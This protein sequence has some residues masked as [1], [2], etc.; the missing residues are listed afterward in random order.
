MGEG[1]TRV[2]FVSPH[3]VLDFTNGA[4]TATLDGLK[5]LSDIGFE[6]EAFCGSRL[7]AWDKEHI[8]A[9][10]QRRG[11]QFALRDAQIGPFHARMIFAS[12]GKVPVTLVDTAPVDG[13]GSPSHAR[14]GLGGPSYNLHREEIA[15]FLTGCEVFLDRFRPDVVW[16]YGG[17]PVALVVQ[18]IA[19]QR[20]I[21]ILF[22]L[23]NFLYRDAAQ[24]AMADCA[25]VPTEFARR[26]YREKLGLEC[27]VL[28]LVIDPGRINCG[29]G[30]QP[31]ANTADWQSAPRFV[32]FVNP[33]PRKGVHVFAR[34]AEVLSNRRPD[35]PLL[36]VEGASK[37]S[38]LPKLG[39]D[40]SG[41][42]N[43]TIWP[44]TPDARRIYA[45]S[46]LILMPSLMENAGC[47][48]MEAM[49][50]GIPVLASNRG[51][52][53]ET[54]GKRPHPHPGP[55][56]EGEGTNLPHPGPVPEGEGATCSTSRRATRLKPATCRRRTKWRS[57]SRRSSASGTTQP[58]TTI[59][60]AP[61]ASVRSRGIRTASRRS[62]A[63]SSAASSISPG[64]CKRTTR[65][66][67]TNRH[68][69][70]K[71]GST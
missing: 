69:R 52:L 42:K 71:I 65:P 22:F 17:D 51:G 12:H 39:I 27:N 20:G 58:S 62:T 61:P 25:V 35:I 38:F 21:P 49:T 32:T 4:A 59:G 33:E 29:A 30:C 53:P 5:L 55:L 28:P 45:A 6:C 43:L 56:P 68:G 70:N 67:A 40:L 26:H 8:E 1:R 3:C 16:T 64:H 63:T 57:G 47:I 7:D 9:V 66:H 60:V 50:N 54:I 10:L 11:E 31:A 18:Q 46:R 41:L 14:D 19:K 48:A 24:F 36:L 23:H 37:A 2:V 34:I 44:N 13:L 15:A